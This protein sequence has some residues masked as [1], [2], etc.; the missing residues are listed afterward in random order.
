[1]KRLMGSLVCLAVWAG[2]GGDD[3]VDVEGTYSVGITNRDNGCQFANWTV[4]ATSSGISVVVTQNGGAAVAEVQ[5]GAAFV[6]NVALGGSTFSGDVDGNHVDMT[7]EGTRPNTTGNCTYTYDARM[8]ANLVGDALMGT[9]AYTA[10]H[11]GHTDCAAIECVS[12][13]DFSGSR[14]PR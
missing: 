4:G 11:N 3:P 2:C 14:P 6:L 9:I 12:N 1:M 5:G 13:Q 8:T 10:A 7:I